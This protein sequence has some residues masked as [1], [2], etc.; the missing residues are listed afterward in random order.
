MERHLRI[1]VSNDLFRGAVKPLQ[2]IEGFFSRRKDIRN[3]MYL[4]TIKY[5]FSKIDQCNLVEKINAWKKEVPQDKFYFRPYGESSVDTSGADDACL[6]DHDED[7]KNNLIRQCSKVVVHSS[8]RS[9]AMTIEKIR[10]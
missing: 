8:D 4:A 7:I 1:Y 3:H 5:R 6:S 9:A 2:R 10:K